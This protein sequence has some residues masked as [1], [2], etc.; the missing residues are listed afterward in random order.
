MACG[1]A[2]TIPRIRRKRLPP[3]VPQTHWKVPAPNL[4][5]SSIPT[6][7]RNFQVPA[8]VRPHRALP[9]ALTF[10]VPRNPSFHR[11]P[12]IFGQSPARK[13][14]GFHRV[15][16]LSKRPRYKNRQVAEKLSTGFRRDIFKSQV[17]EKSATMRL[18]FQKAMTRTSHTSYSTHH[19]GSAEATGTS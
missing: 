1:V 11:V 10:P 18:T 4:E 8:K 16:K 7:K 13:N 2:A 3:R 12:R 19:T 14:L 9:K 5:R 6:M 17:R 15:P